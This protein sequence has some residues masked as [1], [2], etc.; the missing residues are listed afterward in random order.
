MQPT[1]GL[2][3]RTDMAHAIAL[4]SPELEPPETPVPTPRTAD[5]FGTQPAALAERS[6][7]AQSTKLGPA[8]DPMDEAQD[9]LLSQM[10]YDAYLAGLA[11][12]E[13]FESG[14]LGSLSV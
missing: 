4:D 3:K 1:T 2:P 8:T 14:Q 6:A 13:L 10:R 7:S 5:V 11:L 12:Q 9:P